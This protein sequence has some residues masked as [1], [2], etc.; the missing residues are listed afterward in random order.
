MVSNP[1]KPRTIRTTSH[2]ANLVVG[3]DSDLVIASTMV[4][5]GAGNYDFAY[6]TGAIEHPDRRSDIVKI[7]EGGEAALRRRMSKLR[8][9]SV[10][11]GA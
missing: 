8:V 10:I 4:K 5:H 6:A 1:R 9:S 11:G 7:L 3:S 2:N